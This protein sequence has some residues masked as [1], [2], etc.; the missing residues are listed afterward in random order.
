MDWYVPNDTSQLAPLRRELQSLLER[1]STPGSD[2]DG[3]TIVAS[4]LITNALQNS[5]GPVWVSLDWGGSEPVLTVHD[6]GVGFDLDDID[7]PQPEAPRGRGLMIATHLVSQLSVTAKESVGSRVRAALPVSRPLA[8]SIDPPRSRTA[9]LPHPDEMRPDG[10]YG[11]ESFLRA[12]VVQLAESVELVDGPAHAERMVAQV[13]ADVGGR[14]EEAFRA[15]RHLDGDLELDQLAELLVELKAAI[16]GDFY[17][18]DA[19]DDRIVLGN[20]RC[21]FGDAVK[22]A[23][24]LCRMTSSVFGGIASRSRGGAAVDLE[25]RIAVGDPQCKVTVW[26]RPADESRLPFLHAYGD[27][28]R[29]HGEG[30]ST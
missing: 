14:M 15:T 23:P 20:H 2:V 17:V 3:A 30:P 13:G 25:Q 10:T 8:V 6:L 26:L 4:E 9:S 11:R 12:L 5:D 19:N 21:P 1:H 29:G 7:P 22:Q 24:S 16:G 28:P 18:I 27:F